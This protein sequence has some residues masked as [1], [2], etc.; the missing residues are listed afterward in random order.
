MSG[1]API[2]PSPVR[3]DAVVVAAGASRRMAGVDKLMAPIGDR[4][5]LAWTLEALAAAPEVERIVLVVASDAVGAIRAASWLPAKVDAVVAGG[6]R[7]QD[8]VAAGW[9]GSMRSAPPSGDAGRRPGPSATSGSCSSTTA[10]D[11]PSRRPWS[12][13]SPVPRRSTAPRSRSCRSSRRS[14]ASTV[15]G[16]RRPSTGPSCA[17]RRPRRAFGRTCCARRWRVTRRT[18]RSRGPTRP[19]CWR[20]V[21]SPCMQSK[22]SPRTSR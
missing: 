11:R 7:R 12:A 10:A 13:R 20:P 9:P 3:A 4:P 21:E 2:R 16:S 22:A 5:L 8:S 6:E 17:R 19:P 18:G 14:S 15:A 1:N